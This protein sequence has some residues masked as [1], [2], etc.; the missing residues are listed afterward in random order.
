MKK[1]SISREGVYLC[2]SCRSNLRAPGMNDDKKRF[3]RNQNC[4]IKGQDQTSEETLVK[5]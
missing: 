5:K 2:R 4:L 1:G 3:C